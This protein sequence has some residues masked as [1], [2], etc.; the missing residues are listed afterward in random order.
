MQIQLMNIVTQL[1]LIKLKTEEEY[2]YA[3]K[4]C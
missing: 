4:N 1:Q 2:Y 3:G